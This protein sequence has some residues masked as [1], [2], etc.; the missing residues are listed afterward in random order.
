MRVGEVLQN[1]LDF[2][3]TRLQEMQDFEFLI[4]RVDG[5]EERASQVSAVG[6]FDNVNGVISVVHDFQVDLEHVLELLL[7]VQNQRLLFS[8]VFGQV[9]QNVFEVDEVFGML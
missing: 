4:Q 2:N 5:R 1:L 9:F 8:G 7:V 6:L 3:V